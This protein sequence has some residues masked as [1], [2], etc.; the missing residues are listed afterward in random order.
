VWTEHVAFQ[1]AS[2]LNGE[3]FDGFD[4]FP[5]AFRY[6]HNKSGDRFRVVEGIYI[7][8]VILRL[9]YLETGCFC[10]VYDVT[11]VFLG[12]EGEERGGHLLIVW[13]GFY[14]WVLVKSIFIVNHADC[15]TY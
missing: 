6:G 2:H 9:V 14:F 7:D 5:V 12:L 10:R 4:V 8:L 3:L 13:V 11:A 1:T 15:E